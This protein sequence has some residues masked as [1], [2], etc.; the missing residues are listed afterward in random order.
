[1]DSVTETTQTTFPGQQEYYR[2]NVMV[3]VTRTPKEMPTDLAGELKA[4][5]QD[6]LNSLSGLVSGLVMYQ[7]NTPSTDGQAFEFGLPLPEYVSM[8]VSETPEQININTL[9]AWASRY[10]HGFTT[11]DL[12]SPEM[13]VGI[14]LLFFEPNS[15]LTKV[16]HAWR[17]RGIW[18]SRS[19]GSI[20][21]RH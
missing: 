6:K 19:S 15:D 18:I 17:L 10:L 8:R 21:S 16:L 4:L 13:G 12:L 5:F 9:K 20:P 1:M 7:P 2:D 11:T 14:D 3:R